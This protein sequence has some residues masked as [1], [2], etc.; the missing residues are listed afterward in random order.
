MSSAKLIPSKAK[1]INY[2]KNCFIENI[3][4]NWFISHYFS[5]REYS[6][7]QT[8]FAIISANFVDIINGE[9]P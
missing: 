6:P 7:R 9:Y 8:L 5:D 2:K 1:D 3:D 4:E